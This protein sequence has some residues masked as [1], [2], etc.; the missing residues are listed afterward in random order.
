M[1]VSTVRVP[2]AHAAKYIQQL[3]KHWA[4]KLRT[5]LDGDAGVVTFEG[6]VARMK[7]DEKELVVRLEAESEETRDVIKDVIARHLDRF[8]FRE[9]PLPFAWRDGEAADA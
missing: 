1:Q 3:C 8:A 9:A 4:H 5:E 7:A 2:T 6:A